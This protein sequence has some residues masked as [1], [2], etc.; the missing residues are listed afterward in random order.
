MKKTAIMT[1]LVAA[2]L[3]TGCAQSKRVLRS[4]ANDYQEQ[5]GSV[6]KFTVPKG[7]QVDYYPISRPKPDHVAINTL[8]PGFHPQQIIH[9]HA[10]AEAARKAAKKQQ[11][12]AAAEEPVTQTKT[13]ATLTTLPLNMTM[14]TAWSKV[15]S[16]LQ[17]GGYQVL[18]QDE[19]M[20]AYYVL[21]SAQTDNKIT[22]T[23]P[24]ER[25]TLAAKDK[26]VVVS[27]LDQNNKPADDAVSTRILTAIQKHT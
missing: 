24:I 5:A 18:D 2:A 19:S 12:L 4:H 20:H 14:Q 1:S 21:D 15:S 13:M 8:P 26:Q 23:T 6:Q 10:A 9:D 11:H 27:V 16:A 25:V 17:A 3:L 22:T 7:D